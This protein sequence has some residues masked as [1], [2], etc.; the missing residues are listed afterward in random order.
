MHVGERLGR[1]LAEPDN[2]GRAAAAAADAMG[3]VLEVL[4]D[5]DVQDAL[6]SAVERRLEE[7]EVAPLLGKAI[8]VAVEGDHHQ[9][10]LDGVMKGIGGFLED[11]RAM[12]RD[13]LDQE[14][15]WWVPES[16]DDRVFEK[17]F[18]ARTALPGRCVDEPRPRS[19]SVD[20]RT[21]PG[22]RGQVCATTRCS[23]RS[24]SR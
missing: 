2:A 17:I 12:F 20:R 1:W 18:G 3:G 21:D 5:R 13:R 6:G 19:A 9:R 23:S 15:P 7:T 14:S 8:D 24:A 11:N 16:I 10:M 4:D 22:A